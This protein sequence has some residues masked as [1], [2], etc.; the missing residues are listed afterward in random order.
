MRE[1]TYVIEKCNVTGDYS[2][3]VPGVP[4]AYS[5][6]ESLDELKA[7]MIEVMQTVL[8]HEDITELDSVVIGT[9]RIKVPEPCHDYQASERAM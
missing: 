9:D 8:E 2:G 7:S 1:F 6:G 5:C 4:G 3:F